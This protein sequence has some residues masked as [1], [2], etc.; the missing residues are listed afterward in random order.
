MR[1]LWLDIES[2]GLDPLKH[3]ILELAVGLADLSAPFELKTMDRFV[4]RFTDEH[5][6][7][8]GCD[9]RQ[10]PTDAAVQRYLSGGMPTDGPCPACDFDPVAR[11]M[12][13][14]TGLLAECALSTTTVG[15]VEDYL[16]TLVEGQPDRGDDKP[17]LAGSSVGFDLGF[18]RAHA[19]RFAKRLS[20]RVYDVSAV[21]LFFESLGMP[22]IPKANAHMASEDIVESVRHAR[23]CREWLR[24]R[25][26][27]MYEPSAKTSPRPACA[28]E[29]HLFDVE[30]DGWSWCS[31]CGRIC[32]HDQHDTRY[33]ECPL[34]GQRSSAACFHSDEPIAKANAWCTVCGTAFMP[35][36][37]PAR[38]VTP[39]VEPATADRRIAT[40]V[41]TPD[42][43]CA[44][45]R[46]CEGD[47]DS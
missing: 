15:E 12:H 6:H 4:L 45:V 9:A 38:D 10:R 18:L 36:P 14:K 42:G 5:T 20:H 28:G 1:L 26:Q 7:D 16:L 40:C 35:G 30:H 47:D 11:A 22:R 32:N 2:T 24:V 41:T 37:K 8:L 19:P 23:Q 44:S 43:G 46:S 17:T 27:D 29:H 3:S 31:R 21:K 39:C 25:T 34:D 33:P 13:Q